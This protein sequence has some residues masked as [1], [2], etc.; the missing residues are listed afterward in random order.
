MFLNALSAPLL[1]LTLSLS[2]GEQPRSWFDELN[3]SGFAQLSLPIPS[4]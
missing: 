4:R 3:M 2:K 1:P